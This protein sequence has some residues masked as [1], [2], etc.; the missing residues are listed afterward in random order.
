MLK[1]G[2]LWRAVVQGSVLGSELLQ[3]RLGAA[4]Q[5]AGAVVTA[6]PLGLI[7]VPSAVVCCAV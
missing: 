3:V 4:L 6:N 1:C 2:W 7:Q 5:A